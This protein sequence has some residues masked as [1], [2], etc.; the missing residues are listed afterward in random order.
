[1]SGFEG[2]F[3]IP[4]C[5]VMLFHYICQKFEGEIEKTPQINQQWIETTNLNQLATTVV[6]YLSAECCA[7]ML[8]V[9]N[10]SGYV[11]MSF[12]GCI[13]T[14]WTPLCLSSPIESLW[15]NVTPVVQMETRNWMPGSWTHQNP[16]L[17]CADQI[18]WENTHPAITHMDWAAYGNA[19]V[20]VSTETSNSF[21]EIS[22]ELLGELIQCSF[23][24][25]SGFVLSKFSQLTFWGF[26]LVVSPVSFSYLL[27][28]VFQCLVASV[29]YCWCNRLMCYFYVKYLRQEFL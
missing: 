15:C 7:M 27:F 5:H 11:Y 8:L 6:V 21:L 23:L 16:C 26:F 1:M 28:Q 22:P 19:Q 25:G 17:G 20:K 9:R 12:L 4:L 10:L 14:F 18:V 13:S 2:F 29:Q 3:G 24:V